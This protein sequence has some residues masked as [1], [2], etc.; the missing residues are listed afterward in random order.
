[1]GYGFRIGEYSKRL[2]KAVTEFLL[3]LLWIIWKEGQVLYRSRLSLVLSSVLAILVVYREREELSSIMWGLL[4]FTHWPGWFPD[5]FILILTLLT[6]AAAIWEIKGDKLSTSPQEVRFAIAIHNLLILLEKFGYGQ[7]EITLDKFISDF[8]EI[9]RKTL[10]GKKNI[11]CGLMF[12]DDSRNLSLRISS[13]DSNYPERLILPVLSPDRYS[14]CGPAAVA[15]D[16]LKITYMPF[17]RWKKAW[18]F[19]DDPRKDGERPGF[20][21]SDLDV[22]WVSV[23]PALENFRSILCLPVALYVE[24]E[25]KERKAV[26]NYSTTHFDPFVDRDFIMGECFASILAHAFAIAREKATRKLTSVEPS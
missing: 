13:K 21:A 26:I 1:M 10:C 4:S 12:Y 23:D 8:L 25:K 18:L 11:D 16:T 19:T 3:K 24:E 2:G 6:I 5:M 7:E 17:K 9:T 14:E 20:K 22:G 15:I